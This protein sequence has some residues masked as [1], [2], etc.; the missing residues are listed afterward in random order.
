MEGRQNVTLERL[1]YVTSERLENV[2]FTY[3]DVR[4]AEELI[5]EKKIGPRYQIPTV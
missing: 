2:T 1:E 3:P 4:N 5:A